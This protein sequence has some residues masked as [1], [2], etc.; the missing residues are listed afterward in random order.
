MVIIDWLHNVFF[1]LLFQGHVVLTGLIQVSKGWL[2]RFGVLDFNLLFFLLLFFHVLIDWLHNHLFL[3]DLGLLS[4]GFALRGW[5]FS[6]HV[7][8]S[9]NIRKL[10]RSEVAIWAFL[11]KWALS[12]KLRVFV[13]IPIFLLAVF[14]FLNNF[15]P[16]VFGFGFL[17]LILKLYLIYK[18]LQSQCRILLE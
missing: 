18:F 8:V 3:L 10:S 14:F 4:S 11:V 2:V 16:V 12:S 1:F 9:W 15:Y 13:W 17:G 7:V 5:Q 6:H